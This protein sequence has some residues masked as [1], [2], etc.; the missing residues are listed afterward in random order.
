M[1]DVFLTDEQ[2][3]IRNLAKDFATKKIQPKAE[4]I[5]RN[6]RYPAALIKD[7][8]AM[9]WMGIMVAE[10]YGGAGLDPLS[11]ALIIEEV[12]RACA[13]CGVILSVNNSL[14]CF[15]IETWGTD[16][17]KSIFLRPLA[18][19]ESLGC[20]ALSEPDAGSDAAA[21]KTTAK[22]TATGYV[23]NGVKNWITNGAEAEICLLQ[24]MTDKS[25]GHRG[26]TTF[27]VPMNTPGIVLGKKEDKLGIRGSSTVHIQFDG[28]E[29]PDSYRLGNE[30][31]GFKIAM[32]TLDGGRIGIAAQALGIGRAALEAS[33]EYATTRQS[34]GK[35]IGKHQAIAFKLADMATKLEAARLLTWQAALKKAAGKRYSSDAAMAKVAASEAANWVAKEAIQIFG[36]NGYVTDYPVERHY[37]DA[38]ITEI[39]E[40]T[41]EIQRLVIANALL[42]VAKKG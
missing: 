28:V 32:A 4:E 27:V 18:T 35:I 23:I 22:K 11:Y 21:Q 36:G 1:A 2:T 19:G 40:G 29:I 14:V 6:H 33:L 31:E 34:F 9:Q 5:D 41:S 42:K 8:A 17:Q 15:A 39:Y 20:F 3:T 25:A 24:A 13:S 30:G 26:I 12:S 38:K 37:R 10:E 16:E 7:M